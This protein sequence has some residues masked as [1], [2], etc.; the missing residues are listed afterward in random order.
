MRDMKFNPV[1]VVD[2]DLRQWLE[3]SE[4]TRS[5]TEQ[6][7]R[8][9]LERFEDTKKRVQESLILLGSAK[10]ASDAGPAGLIRAE[11]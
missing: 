4:A 8:E 1:E 10:L 11:W 6:I 3:M 2:A 9:S 5:C 7:I